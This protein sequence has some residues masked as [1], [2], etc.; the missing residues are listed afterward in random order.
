MKI[1]SLNL[2]HNQIRDIEILC[3]VPFT[4]LKSLF[5]R[6]NLIDNIGVFTKVPFV[7]LRFLKLTNNKIINFEIL[8]NTSIN[9]GL[10]VYVNRGQYSKIQIDINRHAFVNNKKIKFIDEYY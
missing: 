1:I 10:F 3:E 7:D 4:N 5:L 6:D 8:S 2:D 9:T